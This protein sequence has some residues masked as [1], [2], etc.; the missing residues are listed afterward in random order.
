MILLYQSKEKAEDARLKTEKTINDMIEIE[1]E[2]A[3]LGKAAAERIVLKAQDLLNKGNLLKAEETL[4]YAMGLNPNL[5]KGWEMLS[6][7]QL[8]NLDFEEAYKSAR[9]SGNR[10]YIDLCRKICV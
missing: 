7:M 8:L 6:R 2:K 3:E 5:P 1:K 4:E 10:S 9:A